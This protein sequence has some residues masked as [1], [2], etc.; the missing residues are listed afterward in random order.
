[1]DLVPVFVGQLPPE[2]LPLVL[3]YLEQVGFLEEDA[4]SLTDS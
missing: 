3:D 4:L 2:V 1:M